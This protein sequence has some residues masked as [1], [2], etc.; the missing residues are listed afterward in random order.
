[1]LLTYANVCSLFTLQFCSLLHFRR[2]I[3]FG[4]ACTPTHWC[5]V[6]QSC[7][8]HPCIFDGAAFSVLA[9]SVAPTEAYRLQYTQ[10]CMDAPVSHKRHIR[11]RSLVSV[12][13]HVRHVFRMS[14]LDQSVQIK[15]R[16]ATESR[17][18]TVREVEAECLDEKYQRHPLVVRQSIR[19]APLSL[20]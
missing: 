1:M 5:R 15:T 10:A 3:A 18:D 11:A 12:V 4:P 19:S 13:G 16:V 6:F 2:S 14:S 9:F 8:F 20:V 7:V 17:P